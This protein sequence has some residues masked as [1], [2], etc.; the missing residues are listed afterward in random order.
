MTR[1]EQEKTGT[2]ASFAR[3]ALYQPELASGDGRANA[4]HASA[5]GTLLLPFHCV[6]GV[7]CVCTQ[8]RKR[9]VWVNYKSLPHVPGNFL[10][11]Q[12]YKRI[13]SLVKKIS[14]I[15]NKPNQI[16]LI[17]SIFIMQISQSYLH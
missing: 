12:K 7:W 13:I 8:K 9:E 17:E 5:A 10:Q 11:T 15:L 4:K 14:F 1:L 2:G 6:C 3:N 16:H